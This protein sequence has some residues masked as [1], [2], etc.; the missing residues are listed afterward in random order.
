MPAGWEDDFGGNAWRIIRERLHGDSLALA[1]MEYTNILNRTAIDT[2]ALISDL[3]PEPHPDPDDDT[4]ARVFYG[5][6]NQLNTWGRVYMLYQEGGDL[7]LH[8]YTN[9]PRLM[10]ADALTTDLPE[11]EQWGYEALNGA[12]DQI[13]SGF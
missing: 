8:T 4:L 9:E 6:E 13:A 1:D 5:T 3:T 11:I 10:I 2:G 12:T 7:G